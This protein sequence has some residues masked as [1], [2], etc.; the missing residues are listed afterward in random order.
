MT[1]KLILFDVDGTLVDMA[2][3]GRRAMERAFETV[4]AVRRDGIEQVSYAG[5]TDPLILDATAR[6]A[7]VDPRRFE[8]CRERLVET[9]VREL[10]REL[11]VPDPRR[12]VLPG[13]LPL[14]EHLER[15]EHVHLGLLTGNLEP[16][17]RAK[18]GAFDLNRFFPAGGFASD[19][20]DRREIARIAR[21]KLARVAGI[22]FAAA[23]V[24]VVGDTDHDVDCAKANGYRSV[25]VDSG[26]VPRERL[27][28]AGP[29]VLLDDLSDREEALAALGLGGPD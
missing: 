11:E 12:R 24:T 9:F 20:A 5:R 21:S 27:V 6:A 1:P 13:V 7:G 19:D 17:A 3:V 22:D 14:L 4:L 16:G 18:L 15:L 2:G 10:R 8:A 26:W 25:A 23:D 29:D 28:L